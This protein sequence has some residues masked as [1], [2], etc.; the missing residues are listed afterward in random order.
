MPTGSPVSVKVASI[1]SS[2]IRISWQ[3]PL[4]ELQNGDITSYHI[5]VLELETGVVMSFTTVPTDSIYVVNSLHP[6]YNYNCS[7]AA[8]TIGLGPV[9]FSVVLT[10]P[11]GV[12]YCRKWGEEGEKG[13]EGEGRRE[14]RGEGNGGGGEGGGGEGREEG[15]EGYRKRGK[16]RIEGER[17][18]ERVNQHS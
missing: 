18:E 11:E 15:R 6:F 8:Y 1:S 9:D 3:A 16:G 13:R 17:R 12:C 7:V 5:N 2:S 14:E 4:L 10:L